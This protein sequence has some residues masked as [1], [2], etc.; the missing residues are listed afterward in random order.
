MLVNCVVYFSVRKVFQSSARVVTES[1]NMRKI[2][3]FWM[4]CCLA[5]AHKSVSGNILVLIPIVPKVPVTTC[6]IAT[7]RVSQMKIFK[8]V[9]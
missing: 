1:L 9:A 6:I 5:K 4:V 8:S 2:G 7:T 3:V